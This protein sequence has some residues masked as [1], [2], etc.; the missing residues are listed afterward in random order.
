VQLQVTGFSKSSSA[1]LLA[2]NWL[3]DITNDKGW[4][5]SGEEKKHLIYLFQTT[6]GT[7]YMGQDPV[8]PLTGRLSTSAGIKAWSS[9]KNT[10]YPP[11]AKAPTYLKVPFEFPPSAGWRSKDVTDN[12]T[13]EE[14]GIHFTCICRGASLESCKSRSVVSIMM[15][16]VIS[17]T[18]SLVGLGGIIGLKHYAQRKL[19]R[20]LAIASDQV[21]AA[22][23]NVELDATRVEAINQMEISVRERVE[24][25]IRLMRSAGLCPFI[26]T[27]T[28]Y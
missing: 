21:T 5:S 23:N 7:W 16:A 20:Q 27:C 28:L 2:S 13:I 22:H 3:F 1:W 14:K 19:R 9:T 6:D 12:S 26:V 11:V 25:T 17:I 10:S 24:E 15:W 8:D 4:V 18:I